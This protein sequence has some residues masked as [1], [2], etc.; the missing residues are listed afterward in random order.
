[1]IPRHMH[2]LVVRILLCAVPLFAAAC[3]KV[4][5]TAPTG[6]TITLTTAT[7]TLPINGTATIVAQVI[8]AGGTPPHSGTAV[9]FTTSLGTIEPADASTDASGRTTVTFHAGNA[10][11]IATIAASSGGAT[12]SN[13][14][15]P[16]SGTTG[17]ATGTTTTSDR[18]IRIAVGAAAVGR[19]ILAANP[20]VLPTAG[21][22]TSI[23]A[24]VIDINGNGLSAA[25]VTFTTTAG[26]LSAS[27]VSTDGSGTASVSLT[28]V[29][30]A[31]V[32][33]SVGA[34]A[35][36]G[37]GTGT[38]GTTTQTGSNNQATVT[39]SLT[40]APSLSITVPTTPPSAGLPASY[41]F[42]V[43]A[44]S[45]GGTT[46]PGTTTTTTI[47][48][49]TSPRAV[50]MKS[51]DIDWGDGGPIQSLGAV[52][53]TQAVS[54]T[55]LAARTYT[56]TA[57]ATDVAGGSARVSTSVSVIAVPRPTV[58]VT[59]T[60]QSAPGGTTVSFNIQITAASGLAI[61]NVVIDF[62]DGTSQQLGGATGT[63][64]L[65]HPYAAGPRTL[66]VVV[67]V[68]DATGQS[69]VG[70]TTVSITT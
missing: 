48:A 35:S 38:G 58:I 24:N 19:V 10:S 69:T 31:T 68:T 6:S 4:P 27:V 55:Y 17:T 21:G 54:H 15:T 51:L 2:G 49:T 14:S 70:T 67:T 39:V 41:S 64:V 23:T 33:A 43:S 32:T 44:G 52:T 1:M 65:T 50:A 57:T 7:S 3:E 60:P 56:I 62:G 34:A 42:T 22:V 30:D 18:N 9:L 47:P 37:T 63:I 53:G 59:P 26:T 20:A 16:T 61:S 40:G 13:G 66:N 28:T 45:S 46:S 36:S 25:P 11:G 29:Q 8:E 12:T 5:L